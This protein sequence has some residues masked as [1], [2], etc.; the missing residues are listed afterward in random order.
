MAGR[1]AQRVGSGPAARPGPAE[2]SRAVPSP[3]VSPG[4][5]AC[6]SDRPVLPGASRCAAGQPAAS[7][8]QPGAARWRPQLSQAAPRLGGEMRVLEAKCSGFLLERAACG[9]GWGAQGLLDWGGV[10]AVA[11]SGIGLGRS[12]GQPGAGTGAVWSMGWKFGINSDKPQIS[13]LALI[14]ECEGDET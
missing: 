7:P 2:P 5:A 9:L 12:A 3:R 6:R 13:G 1:A 14:H 8:A 11:R 10:A 4:L